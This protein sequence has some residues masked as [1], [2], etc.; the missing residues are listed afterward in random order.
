MTIRTDITHEVLV[1][2]SIEELTELQV[3]AAGAIAVRKDWANR[4]PKKGNETRSEYCNRVKEETGMSASLAF[5]IAKDL[6]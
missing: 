1:K 2:L 5:D 4:H 6:F 3:M